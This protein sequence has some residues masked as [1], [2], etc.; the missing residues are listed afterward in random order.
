MSEARQQ[1]LEI[2]YKGTY[3]RMPTAELRAKPFGSNVALAAKINRMT[4]EEAKAMK[5]SPRAASSNDKGKGKGKSKG[6]K[7]GKSANKGAGKKKG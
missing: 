2:F 7:G 5:L 6:A 3:I 4:E 1:A